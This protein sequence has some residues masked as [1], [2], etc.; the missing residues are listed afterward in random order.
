MSSMASPF[1]A[2][3][4]WKSKGVTPW[5]EEWFKR[6][7][8]LLS[9]QDAP[10]TVKI[11]KVTSV[12]GD[13]ELGNRKAKLLAIFDCKIEL[14]WTGTTADGTEVTG[15]LV[16]P[17]VSHETTLDQITD[18]Q[19]NWTL[20]TPSSA[21]VDALFAFVKKKLPP[22]LEATF[23]RF[24]VDL[25]QTHGGDLTVKPQSNEP[26]RNGTPAPGASYSPAPPA[27]AGGGAPA[28]APEKPK[29]PAGNTST[30]TVESSFMASADD[31]FSMLT[32]ENRIPMWSRAPAQSKVEVGGSF[33][34][35][36]GGVKG[37][38]ASINRPTQFVQKWVLDHP[39]W[40]GGHSATLTA[41]F[42]QSTESTTVKLALDGVP[43]GMEEEIER[44]IEGY[45]IRGLK[46]IGLGTVL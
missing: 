45:Y 12:D 8:P 25:L 27:A 21:Q 16:I 42:D 1:V 31:L 40:P 43:K 14:N 38:F 26:S 9:V 18:Y 15:K 46:S 4:H 7:L 19:Y 28:P 36:G 39:K 23:A 22:V 34:L 6:E 29:K 37:S 44:N 20:S 35:F 5:A 3:Y 41:S 24:P 13:A 17:E 30:V 11:D 10:G 32:D 2:N 33:S